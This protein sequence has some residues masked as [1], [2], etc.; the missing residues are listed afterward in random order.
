MPV[1]VKGTSER[2]GKPFYNA[3]THTDD[4][5]ARSHLSS[6][7]ARH[8]VFLVGTC[9]RVEARGPGPR[10]DGRRTPPLCGNNM[11]HR[12]LHAAV[13]LGE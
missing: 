1:E 7:A 6:P 13:I 2:F 4:R 12:H 8:C 9:A 11:S 5:D 3:V 10:L